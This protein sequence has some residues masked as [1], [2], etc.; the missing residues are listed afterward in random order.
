MRLQDA[1]Q[2]GIAF[3]G[4]EIRAINLMT[5]MVINFTGGVHFKPLSLGVSL[6]R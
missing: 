3:G 4:I 5:S 1:N 6:C 2:F